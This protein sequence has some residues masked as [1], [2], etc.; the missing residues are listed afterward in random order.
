MSTILTDRD[1]DVLVVTINRPEVRNAIDIATSKV[2]LEAFEEYERDERA[3]V[4]VLT[5]AEGPLRRSGPE[6]NAA[7]HDGDWSRMVR[8]RWVRPV[9]CPKPV[10]AA[11]EGHAVAGGFG[12]TLVRYASPRGTK[13]SA[14]FVAGWGTPA[15]SRHRAA[16]AP[17]GHSTRWTSS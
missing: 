4:A 14:C 7:G 17:L 2:L 1:K 6:G 9:C 12:G 16:S 13:C 11:V 15:R 5:G 3:S 10:L 8:G